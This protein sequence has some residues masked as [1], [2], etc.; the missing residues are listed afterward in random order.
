MERKKKS[1]EELLSE[2]DTSLSSFRHRHD[3]R[4]RWSLKIEQMGVATEEL[5]I[6]C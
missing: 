6:D 1:K 4:S 5:E 3:R 2:Y